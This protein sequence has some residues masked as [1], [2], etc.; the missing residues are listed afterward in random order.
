MTRSPLGTVV[1]CV[2][3]GPRLGFGHLV[4][5]RSLARALG[6]ELVMALRG[7][8]RTRERAAALG[9][10][11]VDVSS[12]AALRAVGPSLMVIDDP[13]A[14]EAERWLHRARR[15][16]VPVATV[17]DV[18]LAYVASDLVIDGSVRAG[19]A[20]AGS[21]MLAGPAYAIL[22]PALDRARSV[23]RKPVPARLLI[24]LGGGHHV[25]AAAALLSAAL[26]RRLPHADLR[27]ARGFAPARAL[28][29]L[30]RGT[31]IDAP[32]GLAAE[33]AEASV[34]IVAGGVTLYEACALGV[35]TV[36]LAVTAAQQ[37]TI[38]AMARHGAV[39]EGGGP[40]LDRECCD[41]V[42]E[43]VI[44]LLTNRERR[45]RQARV[46]RRLVDARGAHRVAHRLRALAHRR[47]LEPTR[48]G[49]H[50]AS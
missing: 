28:P 10:R 18:G 3:A 19:A 23:V 32:D 13:S 24:A 20:P 40:P 42:A 35:P 43:A 25:R 34:A 49:G 50:R 2:A 4:R 6:V 15:A 33:L 47:G 36:A 38:R 8:R 30:S 48:T 26:A 12:G 17:H 45:T 5:C 44:H 22:D 14:P 46:A 1:F 11:L 37:Q 41:K 31:W 7:S 16:G 39:I 27:I 9:G 21:D 29:G